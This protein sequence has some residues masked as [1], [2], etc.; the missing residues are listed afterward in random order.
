MCE[1][2]CKN[3]LNYDYQEVA[4][5]KNFKFPMIVIYKMQMLPKNS[6]LKI[7]NLKD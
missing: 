4:K 7:P 2:H 1:K 6:F 3:A 5:N